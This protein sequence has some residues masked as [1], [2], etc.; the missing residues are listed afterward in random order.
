MTRALRLFAALGPGDIVSA[1]R[2]QLNGQ[3]VHSETSLL[4]SSQIIE[5][6][7][8]RDIELLGMSQNGRRD[9]IADGKIVLENSPIL[10]GGRKGA[11]Y[12]MSQF[13]RGLYLAACARQFN[14][15]FALIASGSG[16]YF[17]FAAFPICG[18]PVALDFHNA[19][20]PKG[21]QNFRGIK[22]G[23][24][25]LDTMFFRHAMSGSIGVSEE[26]GRQVQAAT[27]GRSP[28][29]DYKCQFSEQEFADVSTR[30]M[31]ADG[32]FRVAFVGRIERNKG[33]FDLL[34]IANQLKSHPVKF[35]V[36]GGGPALELLRD[37]VASRGL[38]TIVTLHGPL[39]RPDLL[40]MYGS[41]DAVIVPTTS[42]FAEG[43][44]KVCAEAVLCNRPLV[45]SSL[46]NAC[47]ALGPALALCTPNDPNSYAD[48]I[49][50][51]LQNRDRYMSLVA[52]CKSLQAQFFGRDNSIAAALDHLLAVQVAG[53]TPL[54]TYRRV[55]DAVI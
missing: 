9:T 11:G 52:A 48:Q 38:G 6:C 5:Y 31:M 36:C 42:E 20:W 40:K 12:H 51:L 30:E 35:D 43:L 34:E 33:V 25:H 26:C 10:F 55:F 29:F 27:Q 41:C 16:H 14:A 37:Q 24:H 22:R 50:S 46:S 28:Y 21:F 49:L 17:S 19:L 47:D 13:L 4:Y 23:I 44:P 7:K 8:L 18:V 15:N 45:T 1:Y 2:A 39:K 32:H 54:G 53:W 3:S